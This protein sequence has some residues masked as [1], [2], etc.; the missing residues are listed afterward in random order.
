MAGDGIDDLIAMKS[1]LKL[2]RKKYLSFLAR[3][4]KRY[5]N[6]VF[7][8]SL[9]ERLAT[10]DA[11]LA[12]WEEQYKRNV[13]KLSYDLDKLSWDISITNL[14]LHTFTLGL[15]TSLVASA[16]ERLERL[17]QIALCLARVSPI[18]DKNDWW[19]VAGLP[20]TFYEH[21]VQKQDSV[22]AEEITKIIVKFF[23]HEKAKKLGQIVESWNAAPFTLREQ[24]FDEAL[25]AHQ[26]ARFNLSVSV[27][28][29]QV[30]GLIRDFVATKYAFT[31]RS[32][33]RVRGVFSSRFKVLT[34]LL[35]E[36]TATVEEV[37]AIVNYHNLKKLDELYDA[38]DPSSHH[39]SE[40]LRRHAVAHGLSL[41]YGTVEL[42]T[43][44]FL[45]LDMLHS[46]VKQIELQK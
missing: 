19:L 44:L 4:S 20:I 8:E 42:S 29:G 5:R 14:Q 2:A 9:V 43:R 17:D 16:I 41:N 28:I 27:L 30:E 6:R 13:Q 39:K 15:S 22:T 26:N 45:L 25:W 35:T 23:N 31:H 7:R 46:M 18:M 10:S 38:Y 40:R 11:D 21:I 34:E 36:N 32:F 33:Y 1:V 24:F 37:N 12:K 3:F